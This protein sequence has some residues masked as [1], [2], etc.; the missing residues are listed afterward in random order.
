MQE[1]G[2]TPPVDI[3]LP[4]PLPSPTLSPASGPL[5]RNQA[6]SKAACEALSTPWKGPADFCYG[7]DGVFEDS[8]DVSGQSAQLVPIPDPVE[9]EPESSDTNSESDADDDGAGSNGSDTEEFPD[10]F[11]TDADLNAD[12]YSKYTIISSYR[13]SGLFLTNTTTQHLRTSVWTTL[14]YS[15]S[16][17]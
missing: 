17:R 11:Q 12:E 7:D 9:P 10:I 8:N 15:V 5:P 1:F 3:P 13:P 2:Y 14:T 4:D 16:S 6:I